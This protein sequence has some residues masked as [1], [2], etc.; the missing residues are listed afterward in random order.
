MMIAKERL[1]LQNLTLNS[2]LQVGKKSAESFG[3]VLFFEVAGSGPS[4]PAT[5]VK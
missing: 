2:V 3:K 5:S 1:D 4:S